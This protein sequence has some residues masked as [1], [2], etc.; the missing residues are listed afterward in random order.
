MLTAPQIVRI[1]PGPERRE[2]PDGAGLYLVVQPSGAK[3]FALRFRRPSGRPAKLTLGPF[4]DKEMEGVPTVGQPLTLA[5]AR[6]LAAEQKRA[7]ALDRDPAEERQVARMERRA[8]AAHTFADAARRYVERHARP[9]LR[10]WEEE[11]RRLGIDPSQQD[12]PLLA[13]GLAERWRDKPVATIT[14]KEIVLLRNEVEERGVPGLPRR[15]QD[16]RSRARKM[17]GTLREMFGWLQAN[18]EV[19]E[20]PAATVRRPK[21]P[22]ARERVLAEAEIRAFWQAAGEL[23]SVLAP[24]LRLLLVTGQRLNEVARMERSELSA[25]DTTWTIPG[26]RTKNRREHVVPLPPLARE[27]LASVPAIRGCPFVFSLNG[28]TPIWVGDKVKRALDGEMADRKLQHWRLHDLRR[29]AATGMGEND[30]DP[31]VIERVLNHI[32]GTFA[33]VVGVYNRAKM[34]G[35]KRD[36]L[37]VWSRQV[38]RIVA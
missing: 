36:A 19:A 20:N 7:L 24:L 25:D 28:R 8:V 34:E 32:S 13:K 35:K 2:V 6:Q 22:R 17:V 31:H 27:L 16:G 4:S 26:R 33:G 9:N 21:Q 10:R 15:S 3:S 12:L 5:A 29:T 11:A 14:S 38:A 30:V 18:E 23:G 1:K 37:E